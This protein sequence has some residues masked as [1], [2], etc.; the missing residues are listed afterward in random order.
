M[1]LSLRTESLTAAFNAGAAAATRGTLSSEPSEKTQETVSLIQR[2]S[3]RSAQEKLRQQCILWV[4]DQPANNA[5]EQSVFSA[6]GVDVDIALDTQE[7]LDILKNRHYDLIISDMGRP[8]GSRA[9]YE[10][11]A[12]IRRIGIKTPFLIYAGSSAPEHTREALER[13]AQGSTNDPQALFALA[14]D[15]LAI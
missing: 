13:G 1:E 11:L 4:D 5:Y 6:L 15:Y 7:A 8:S 9:G 10:L 3:G 14:L 12:K 2:A